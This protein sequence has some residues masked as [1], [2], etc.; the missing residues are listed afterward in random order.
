MPPKPD[1]YLVW[2]ILVTLFCCLPFGIVAIVK[3]CAV[4]SAYN[5]GNA[6]LAQQEAAAAKKWCLIGLVCGLVVAALYTA[7]IAII[8]PNLTCC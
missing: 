5:S 4:D 3:S 6:E 2:S 1:N 7:L 8:G